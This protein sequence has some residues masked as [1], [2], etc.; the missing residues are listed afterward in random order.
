M[1]LN[2]VLKEVHVGHETVLDVAGKDGDRKLTVVMRKALHEAP[3]RVESPPRAHEF[4][5]AAGFASYLAAH[6]G[7]SPVVFADQPA[8]R[9]HAVLDERAD[10]GFE[11]VTCV[12]KD[13]PLWA[14]WAALIGRKVP[15]KDFAAFVVANRR[16][17]AAPDGRGLARLLS[18]VRGAVSVEIHQGRGRESVNGLIVRAKVQGVEKGEPVDLPETIVLDVP[19]YVAT[20]PVK[21]EIDL[22]VDANEKGDVSVALA[23]AGAEVAKV[24]A[25]AAMVATVKAGAPK[26]LVTL[27]RPNHARWYYR[28]AGES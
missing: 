19:L 23:S 27:G 28:Q 7:E 14:P 8:S 2:E 16:P 21:V 3:E 9:I 1:N 5:E 15:L 26:A 12:P 20:A 17:I 22:T 18:Q 10:K 24:E 4:H 6:G 25:F 13:H 11:V